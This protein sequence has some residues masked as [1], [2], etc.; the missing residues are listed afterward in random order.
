MTPK[1]A[2]TSLKGIAPN[3]LPK[4]S[5]QTTE[6]VALMYAA[7]DYVVDLSPLKDVRTHMLQVLLQSD[8]KNYYVDARWGYLRSFVAGVNKQLVKYGHAIDFD[9]LLNDEVQPGSGSLEARLRRVI[10]FLENEATRAR[11]RLKD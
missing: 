5:D 9:R 11:T 4:F 6:M 8:R 7:L 1:N 3:F 2:P 10:V